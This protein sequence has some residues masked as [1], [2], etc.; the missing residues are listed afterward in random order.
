LIHY[1]FI[2]LLA[3]IIQE[4]FITDIGTLLPDFQEIKNEIWLL[5]IIFLYQVG[6]SHRTATMQSDFQPRGLEY[7][8]ELIPR[9]RRY[10][11][12]NFYKYKEKYSFIIDPIIKENFQVGILIYSILIFENFNRPYLIRKLEN[13]KFTITKKSGT[14]GIMQVLSNKPLTDPDS[15]SIGSEALVAEYKKL[16]RDDKYGLYG[17][18][19]K[20]H[21]PDRIYI[22]QVLFIS[23][24]IIDHAY[25]K[26]DRKEKFKDLYGQ[27]SNEFGLYFYN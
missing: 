26:V 6:N 17:Y 11:L 19:I 9:K 1:S 7:L 8:P 22:R 20:H 23:K 3:S 2:L 14:F 5:I 16:E 21:C 4:R 25:T 18:L 10:I 27:I 12:R 15:I 13:L 24:A